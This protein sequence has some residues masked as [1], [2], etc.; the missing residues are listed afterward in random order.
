MKD[1]EESKEQLMNELEELRQ[2][3][4]KLEASEAKRKQA[5]VALQKSEA[6]YRSLFENM[7]NGFAYCKI[8]LD[9][10]SQPIDFV[11]LEVNDSFEKLTGLRKEDVVGK[12]VT[13]AIPT[14]EDTHPE[15]FDIYGK[16]ALTGKEAEFDIYFEPLDIWLSISVYS[17][18]KGYFVAVF[19]NITERKQA[20]VALRNSEERL[21]Q[22]QRIGAV[23][24]WEFD[25]ASQEIYWSEEV[26]RLFER[27]PGQGP[28]TYEENMAYYYP[29][30]SKKLQE[31]VRRAIESGEEFDTDYRLK[32]PSGKSV[33]QRGIITTKK[34]QNGRVI[35]LY[36]TVQDIT[37]RKRAEE[38][39]RKAHDGLEQRTAELVRL[40]EKLQQEI[41][42]RKQVEQ[43]LKKREAE[44]EIQTSE[45][46]EVN[47][48]LRVLLK[49]RDEDKTDLEEKILFNVK[50]LVVP[51]VEKLKKGRFDAR[52]T[53][54]VGILESN[55]NDIISPFAHKMSSKYLGLTPTEIQI[56]NLVKQ[57][58]TTKAIAEILNSSDRTVEFH[59]KNI[60][61]KIGIVNR[62]VNLRSHLLSM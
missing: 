41:E 23:G 39:L 59:R 7:L 24:D 45:L 25:V 6:K 51:Y 53:A 60:R 13:E 9:E 38:A 11:Y 56:A 50:E 37:E 29:E 55:L 16:V 57:G 12:R 27:D 4:A 31:Q 52:H 5:E 15:L 36:G 62:K 17:P 28:P 54:Y 42:E 35:K 2:R 22:A 8:L 19:D 32:L 30:D 10:N 3:I 18:Q 58:R 44:L 21:K 34:D 33:Y 49:R 47:S 48:A 14:I 46:E 20:E 1:A 26:Y 43:E 40:N 61:K